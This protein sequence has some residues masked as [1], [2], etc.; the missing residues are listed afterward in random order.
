[1][2][3]AD[4]AEDAALRLASELSDILADVR[5]PVS[6]LTESL[7]ERLSF[8]LARANFEQCLEELRQEHDIS[9]GN[10]TR[11]LFEEAMR[12][13]WVD[14]DEE[15]RRSA[16]LGAAA[17]RHRQLDDAARQLGMDVTPYYGPL[18]AKVLDASEGAER[19]PRQIEGQLE[20]GL[21][22]LSAFLYAQYRLL[23]QYTHSSLLA[24]ASAVA[25]R[26]GYL[27]V[28]RLP[29]A[30]RL[31]I[32]RNAVSNM[33]VIVD[34]CKNGLESFVDGSAVPLNLLSMS[35]AVKVADLVEPFTPSTG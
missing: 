7:P 27:V 35:Y 12:W 23:S 31:T 3:T 11:A 2:M 26:D 22:D 32:L 6:E 19:F 16:F 15:N 20:W 34:G 17:H 18:V 29:Q 30:A 28:D 4:Y 25:E 9:A 1:M 21:G 10:L 8:L 14:E 24:I 13:A 33:V 5:V